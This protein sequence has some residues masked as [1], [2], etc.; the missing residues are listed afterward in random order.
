MKK[1]FTEEQIIGV[2]VR[3]GYR[4]KPPQVTRSS[5]NQLNFRVVLVVRKV[6]TVCLAIQNGD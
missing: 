6:M 2:H 3:P 4:D 5:N 1:R